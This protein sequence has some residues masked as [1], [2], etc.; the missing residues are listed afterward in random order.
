MDKDPVQ[1]GVTI[2][3]GMLH[4]KE[5][6][7]SSSRL[8]L[9]LMCTFYCIDVL[10]IK[11]INMLFSFF[12]WQHFDETAHNSLLKEMFTQVCAIHREGFGC[13][14][15]FACFFFF[16]YNPRGHV[17]TSLH[18]LLQIF[19]TPCYHPKSKPFIDHIL[20]F[21]IEDNRIWFRNFQVNTLS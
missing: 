10:S 1:G 18:F 13:L 2:L 21:S 6:G 19:S 12:T 3:M 14:F 20:S 17:W 11:N 16:Y 15:C 9:S 8:G 5:T 4:A 7:I